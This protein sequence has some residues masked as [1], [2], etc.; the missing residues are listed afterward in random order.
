MGNYCNVCRKDEELKHEE[1]FPEMSAAPNYISQ[2]IFTQAFE[3]KLPLFG[4]Y[5][6]FPDYENKLPQNIKNYIKKNPIDYRKNITNKE[7][8]ETPQPIE[9]KNGNI[10]CGNWNMNSL[11]DGY[12]K[13]FLKDDKVL[14]EGVWENGIL[15]LGRI[16]LPNGDIYEG[17]IKNSLFNGKG[18]M[19]YSNGTIFEGNFINGERGNY[20]KIIYDDGSYYLGNF[21][22]DLPN[23]KGEF[24]WKNGYLYKGNFIDGKIEGEGEIKNEKSGSFYKGNFKNNNF[25]DKGNFKFS[26][27]SIYKGEYYLGKKDGEGIYNKYDGIKY[28]GNFSNGK[29]NGTGIVEDENYIYKCTWRNGIVVETP[30]I[31]VKNSD[32]AHTGNLDLN[33]K[34][35]DEDINMD[36]LK[37]LERDLYGNGSDS[38]YNGNQGFVQVS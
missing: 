30:I 23:G 6:S 1:T 36:K 9:F 15:K 34:V 11:M 12:G 38:N 5:C 19:I 29:L 25:H 31:E 3:K 21:K 27:G 26:S 7:I 32:S 8:Y 37:Y 33:F 28:N 13:Y 35:E 18:K 14:I 2:N 10:Y 16:F 22:N 4:S 20:G 24:K 17:E